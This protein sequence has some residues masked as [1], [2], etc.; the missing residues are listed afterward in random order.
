MVRKLSD[1]SN[2]I[3][4]NQMR[5]N[6]EVIIVT[7]IGQSEKAVHVD[8]MGYQFWVPRSIIIDS[9]PD[10][11]KVDDEIRFKIKLWWYRKE[12]KKRRK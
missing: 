9:I 1:R 10:K 6:F 4:P 3:P 12:L 5:C 11:W 2:Y 8:Q 7:V